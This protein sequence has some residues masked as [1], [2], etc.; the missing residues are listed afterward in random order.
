MNLIYLILVKNKG[1][2]YM[3]IK[4]LISFINKNTG[5]TKANLIKMTQ[6]EF[7]LTKK[8]SVFIHEE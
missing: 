5:V 3:N 4:N 8:R 7:Q 2:T 1:G 6:D